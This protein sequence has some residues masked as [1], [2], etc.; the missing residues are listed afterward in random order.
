M[1]EPALHE[2]AWWRCC[3]LWMGLHLLKC[4]E[5]KWC[6]SRQW[7]LL[8]RMT[9]ESVLIS[10][11]DKELFV[12]KREFPLLYLLLSILDSKKFNSH[13]FNSF[14]PMPLKF[15]YVLSLFFFVCWTNSFHWPLIQQY[16]LPR[17]E[18][19]PTHILWRLLSSDE[20][21]GEK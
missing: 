20:G 16:Y 14:T 21:G 9:R 10:I 2:K 17:M 19:S 1:L 12:L 7:A 11:I 3:F 5:Q 4:N 13:L 15:Q 18:S 6:F 8:F